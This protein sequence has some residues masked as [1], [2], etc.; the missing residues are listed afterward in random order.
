MAFSLKRLTTRGLFTAWSV[1]WAALLV[2]AGRTLVRI[3]GI[4]SSAAKG[5]ASVTATLDDGRVRLDALLDGRMVESGSA[6][7]LALALW[8]AGPPLLLWLVWL[9]QRPP[10]DAVPDGAR[11]PL[12]TGQRWTPTSYHAAL[13]RE[14][15]REQDEV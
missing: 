1:Y 4:V 8:I 12:L 5:H 13:R 2:V 11:D 6:S 7:L 9:L 3:V 14:T 10:H 15:M